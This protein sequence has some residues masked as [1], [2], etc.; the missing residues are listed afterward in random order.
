MSRKTAF[1]PKLAHCIQCQN[2]TLYRFYRN[3]I[4]ARCQFRKH[5]N[6]AE[7]LTLCPDFKQRKAPP[8]IRQYTYDN[9]PHKTH[10][11]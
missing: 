6:V 1:S 8:I 3:P 7:S 11:S 2:A 5:P 9:N 10:H 4:L